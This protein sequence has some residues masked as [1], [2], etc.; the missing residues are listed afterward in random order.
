MTVDDA[1]LRYLIKKCLAGS[2]ED[3]KNG[4]SPLTIKTICEELIAAREGAK[5]PAEIASRDA[6]IAKLEAALQLIACYKS[7][8]DLAELGPWDAEEALKP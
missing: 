2:T 7:R 4:L 3:W 1:Q 6:R 8:P 5:H